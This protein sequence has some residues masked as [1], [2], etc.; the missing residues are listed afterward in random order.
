M[1]FYDQNYGSSDSLSKVSSFLDV[2][3]Q[4]NVVN[5]IYRQKLVI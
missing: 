4:L 1:V 3:L 5:Q 2:R